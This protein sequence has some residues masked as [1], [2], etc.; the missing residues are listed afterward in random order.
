V[1]IYDQLDHIATPA[2]GMPGCDTLD[3]YRREHIAMPRPP[4]GPVPAFVNAGRWLVRCA[5]GDAPMAHPDWPEVRCFNCGAIGGHVIWPAER[6]DIERV[7]LA[8]P[9]AVNRNW[10][11]GES[12]EDLQ[13]E[14]RDHGMAVRCV[15]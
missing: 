4:M 8:R 3:H 9:R 10:M 13:R 5:C 1:K 7:L 2:D 14:N 12:V 6:A 11:P 15:D